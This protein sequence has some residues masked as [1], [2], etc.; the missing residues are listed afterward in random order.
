[1]EKQPIH[2][3]SVCYWGKGDGEIIA[4]SCHTVT[5]QASKLAEIHVD[6][7]SKGMG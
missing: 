4:A 6:N 3:R 2:I 5:Y 7:N 1:M